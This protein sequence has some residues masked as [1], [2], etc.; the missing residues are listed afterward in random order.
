MSLKCFYGDFRDHNSSRIYSKRGRKLLGVTPFCYSFRALGNKFVAEFLRSGPHMTQE[1]ASMLTER[2]KG[3]RGGDA[4]RYARYGR[5]SR[6]PWVFR[7]AQNSL[8]A[9]QK[10]LTRWFV[11]HHLAPTG[12]PNIEINIMNKYYIKIINNMY[13]DMDTLK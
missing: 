4:T 13:F 2:K 6:H 10:A 7:F 12:C 11:P 5:H 3:I 9:S 8:F 1:C